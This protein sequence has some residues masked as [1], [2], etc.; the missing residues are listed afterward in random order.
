MSTG[1]GPMPR[2]AALYDKGFK[3]PLKLKVIKVSFES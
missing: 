2:P 1:F 3:E